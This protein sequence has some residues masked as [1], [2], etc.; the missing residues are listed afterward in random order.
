MNDYIS[1]ISSLIIFLF[2][3]LGRKWFNPQLLS[4]TVVSLGLL[5]TFGGIMYGLWVFSVE[6]IDSSIP[7]LLEGLKTAFLTSIA[8]MLASLILKLVPVFYGIRKEEEQEEEVT[9]K[10]LLLVLEN[11]EKNTQ[12]TAT[13][14][15]V[16]E[17]KLSNEQLKNNFQSLND[18][19]QNMVARELH[20]NTEAL[21][22]SL[23]SVISNLDNRISEQINQTILK[24]YDILEQQLQHIIH[25]QEFNQ[26]IQEQLQDTLSKL[27]ETIQNI[28]TFLGKSNNLNMKQNHVFMEQVTSFGEFIKGSEQ[29]MSS[30]LN[31]ME[32]KYERELT[33][34]EK[35]TK[36]LMTIIKKLSQDH[37]TLYKKTN[38]V[39]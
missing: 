34:L 39:E 12:P 26:T 27:Q 9:D 6:Q 23:Q 24:I 15:L 3:Y 18:N 31:R 22:S 11:I 14:A 35:F 30:Q 28:E 10:Q 36:T 13:L 29:Q 2:P 17:V 21:A 1:I 32:E 33:E 20:F 4:S 5:G 16:Q 8:G 38:D 19:L 7:Q 37:D 25:S